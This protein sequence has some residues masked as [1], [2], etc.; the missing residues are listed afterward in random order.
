[1]ELDNLTLGEIKQL[2]CIIGGNAEHGLS[3]RLPMHVGKNVFVMTVTCYF[4]GRIEAVSEDE[5]RL[6]DA[7][8]IADTGRFSDA[9]KKAEFNEVEPLPDGQAITLC[10]AAIVSWTEISTLPRSQK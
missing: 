10:R 7:A 6:V 2:K 8:W 4:T 5:V 1:M 3:K 9:I